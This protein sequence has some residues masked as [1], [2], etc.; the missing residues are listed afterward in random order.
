M[1]EERGTPAVTFAEGELAGL[2]PKPTIWWHIALF[3]RKRPL[4]A[5]GATVA[6]LLIVVAIF[7]PLIKT[8]SEYKSN[9]ERVY[10]EPS[11]DMLFGGDHLGRDVFSRIIVGSR[12]SLRVGLISA[13]VGSAIGLLIG[14]ASA[15]FGGLTDLLVQRII[16]AL[17][18]F[19]GLVL[20]IAIVASLGASINN[21]IA[22]LC[23]L[24]IP[25]TARLIRSQTLAVKEMDYVL[26]ARSV[27]AGDLRIMWRHIVPQVTAVLIVVITFQV[28]VAIIAEAALSFLGLG[29][30]PE[31]P[32]WGGMLRGAAQ[33]VVGVGPWLA[34]FPGVAIAVVVFSWNV[35]GD[36]LRDVL[37]PRLRG[38]S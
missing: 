1:S 7:A 33:T 23:I 31:E 38:S 27:G 16:D 20:A 5:F 22:A 12:I 32:S 24:F 34:I 14:V 9:F 2:R 21:V 28:G 18:A 6:L 3:Y 17:I 10:A 37:D 26:A 4:G 25:G 15:Y 35:L 13:F 36:A 19:P 29:A 8:Q 11:K 30:G